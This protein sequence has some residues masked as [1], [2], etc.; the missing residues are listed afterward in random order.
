MTYTPKP[1]DSVKATLGESVLY[2]TVDETYTGNSFSVLINGDDYA[3]VF[4]ASYWTFE[5]WVKPV[6]F[7]PLTV[8]KLNGYE[9]E[10]ATSPFLV[11]THA[12]NGGGWYFFEN[13]GEIEYPDHDV[14]EWLT[15]G[16]AEILF[17]GV[18]E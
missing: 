18:D 9:V 6:T 7:K 15:L 2:G 11:R 13:H 3:R 8:V 12:S 16:H 1:G 17:E 10:Y 5:P 4:E 14:A